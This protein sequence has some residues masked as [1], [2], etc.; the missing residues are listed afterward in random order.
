[1]KIT[2]WNEFYHETHDAHVMKIYPDGIHNCIA[3][4]LRDAG[5]EVTTAT[6]EDPECGLTEEV[7]TNTDV[8]FWWGHCRHADVPDEVVARV[9]KRFIDGMGM[10]VL[11][12][13][14]ASKI[15]QKLCGTPSVRLKWRLTEDTEILWSVAPGHPITRGIGDRIIIEKEE[16]YGEHFMIP[17]PDELLFIGWFSGGEVFRSGCVFNRG[18]GKIFYFQP[19]HEEYP[20][21]HIPDIQKVLINAASYVY[22]PSEPE[23]LY[24]HAEVPAI[25]DALK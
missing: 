21:Y 17:A 19:G 23:Y 1:M 14:H 22:T 12:S 9:Y 8:L 10:V 5:H 7:L 2:V 3:R 11:H 25:K 6:L 20:V 15:F 24:G 13:G 18:K 4:F 16:T